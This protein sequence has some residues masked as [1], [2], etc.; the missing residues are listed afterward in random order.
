[1]RLRA[2]G[3]EL[4]GS[5]SGD[6][7][8]AVA[9]TVSLLTSQ[10]RALLLPGQDDPASASASGAGHTV[11]LLPLRRCPVRFCV[12][13]PASLQ[14]RCPH[15]RP[16]WQP[17]WRTA[18]RNGSP[19]LPWP[20]A[21]W[22]ACSPPS[23][24]PSCCRHPPSPRPPGRR[25]RRCPTL[26]HPRS[27]ARARAPRRRR[28]PPLRRRLRL[29]LRRRLS[30]GADAGAA[31]LPGALA[32]TVTDRAGDRVRLPGGPDPAGRRRGRPGVGAARP[33]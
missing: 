18:P 10:A 16:R 20:T 31:T 14:L 11:A 3:E 22:P 1:M 26:P 9:Q 19:T 21:A 33:A 17:H 15:R 28:R 4:G 27:P 29:L 6:A 24:P 23:G 13:L 2:A 7:K 5:A 12:R 8:P 32:A 30:A 25:P